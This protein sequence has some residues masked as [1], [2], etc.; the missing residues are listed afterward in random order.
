MY[1]KRLLQMQKTP[2]RCHSVLSNTLWKRQAAAFVLSML[3]INAAAWR[4][5]R[6]HSVCTAFAQRC[7][8]LHSAHLGVLQFFKRCGNAVRTPLWCDSGLNCLKNRGCCVLVQA[9]LPEGFP[10]HQFNL[11]YYSACVAAVKSRLVLHH[12][13]DIFFGSI[14]IMECTCIICT[15]EKQPGCF[16][17][18]NISVNKLRSVTFMY[19]FEKELTMKDFLNT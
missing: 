18:L 19:L 12:C 17:V 7:W 1:C 5:R 15:F 10:F 9:M 13:V 14:G 2:Q 8:R 3:K 4:S 6:L 11:T 16:F